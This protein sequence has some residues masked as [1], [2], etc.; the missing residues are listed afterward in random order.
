MNKILSYGFAAALVLFTALPALANS[1]DVC[2]DQGD[3]VVNGFN[4]A[5]VAS[6]YPGGTVSKS[7]AGV[8]CSALSASPIGTFFAQGVAVSELPKASATDSCMWFGISASTDRAPLTPRD[9]PRPRQPI[10]RP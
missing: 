4:F 6:V 9:R 1:Y 5:A 10:R 7:T 3:D 8:E 2:L